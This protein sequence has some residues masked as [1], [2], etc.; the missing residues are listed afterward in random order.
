[1]KKFCFVY[2]KRT[3]SLERYEIIPASLHPDFDELISSFKLFTKFELID[4]ESIDSK[5]SLFITFESFDSNQ[6]G[7]YDFI[8]SFLKSISL[9]N[10][11]F[12]L[13]SYDNQE[14]N[15]KDI[16]ELCNLIQIENYVISK[17]LIKNRD[18][19]LWFEELMFHYIQPTSLI[20]QNIL[21]FKQIEKASNEV[22][23]KFKG[24]FYAGHSRI[25]K[26]QFLE[27]L[28][29][30]DY[31]KDFIWASTGP[32]FAPHMLNEFVPV[33][34][35]EEYNHMKILNELP[36]LNDYEN[37]EIY[38][39]RGN[40]YNFTSYLDSYFDIVAETRFYHIQNVK[41]SANT[42]L[43]W[44][45]I[46]EKPM[47]PTLMGHPFII[48]SKPNTISTLEDMGL[49]YRYDFWNHSYDN[50][51]NDFERMSA[52]KD[53]TK[54]VMSLSKR[55]LKEFKQDYNNYTKDNFD[56]LNEI[57]Q[58]SIIKIYEKA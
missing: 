51:N 14:I 47:K 39:E 24:M 57:Y 4:L 26:L 40:A 2:L 54:K 20:P 55:E 27:F 10:V 19:Q 6:M 23:R 15:Q 37:Y 38:K 32:D 44:N 30:N 52:V 7:Q 17:N 3:N 28:Y 29:Q 43:N 22:L 36:H 12:D 13:S 31:L 53:F 45:N 46:S 42:F 34:F 48:I 41:G 50:I 33:P 8:N 5:T 35:L 56:V 11:F 21:A 9:K 58:N 16:D 49:K 18:N 25:H 1:M